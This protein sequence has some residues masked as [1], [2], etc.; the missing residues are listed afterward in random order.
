MDHDHGVLGHKSLVTG[1]GDDGGCTGA[2]PFH[3]RMDRNGASLDVVEKTKRG[4]YAAPVTVDVQMDVEVGL[5]GDGQIVLDEELS[6]LNPFFV[7]LLDDLQYGLLF[8]LA[9][10]KDI[11]AVGRCTILQDHRLLEQVRVFPISIFSWD[12]VA[13]HVASFQDGFR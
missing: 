2:H 3:M 13:N 7:D 6:I 5:N 12:F 8:D 10:E 11:V 9:V 1:N 4:E